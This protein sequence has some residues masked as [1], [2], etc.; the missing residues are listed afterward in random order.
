MVGET[1]S[2]VDEKIPFMAHLE[3][4]RRR[5]II[6]FVAIGIGFAA[7][8]YFSKQIFDILMQ[9]LLE[10]L[11]PEGS[12]IFTGLTEAF[13]TYLKVALLTGIFAAS[14]VILYQI[15]SFIAPGLYEKEK[16]YA[17]PFVFFSTLFFVGGALFG[18]F[19]VFPF[20]FK[21]FMS[22]ASE[23]ILP[24][25]SVKEYLA[26]ST[27]LLFAFGIVFELPL[28]VFFLTKIGVVNAEMLSSQRKYA[29]IAVF[30]FSA[31][32]TPP[33]VISQLMMAGPL[34]ILYE[35]SVLVSR[36]MGKKEESS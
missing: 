23:T 24:L 27:K 1:I 33:D 28:F 29:L 4:L 32:L 17:Y 15:W 35:A 8:Y 11:P 20:G 3:E 19:A 14:P 12:L 6:C 5:L 10:A 9:P 34:L 25:P 21:F 13:I 36:V 16:K 22:F 31:V 7:S 18:Y 30:I 26:F 2:V